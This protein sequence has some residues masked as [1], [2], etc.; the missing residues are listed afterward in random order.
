MNLEKI[1]E[2]AYKLYMPQLKDEIKDLAGFVQK[3]KPS[4]IVEIGTKYG[5]T[6]MI[7]NEISDGLK[8]SIDLTDGIHGGVSN[9][10]IVNRD[11]FFK[12]K[13]GENCIFINGNSHSISTYEKLLSVLNGKKIDFLF[14]DGDHTYEGVKSD[15]NMYNTLVKK[16]GYI[17]F[18]DINDSENHRKRNVHVCQLWQELNYDKIEFNSNEDWGGIGVIKL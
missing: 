18:H 10:D 7:W 2:N 12:K 3:Q 11:N 17:A 14:I 5:G 4:V 13:Y 6:F 9:E 1:I 16:G 15:F 8:I